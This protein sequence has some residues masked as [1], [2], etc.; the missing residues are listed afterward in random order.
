[1]PS[2]RKCVLYY[3]IFEFC[4]SSSVVRIFIFVV[5]VF[6]ARIS[7]FSKYPFKDNNNLGGR[8]RRGDVGYCRKEDKCAAE[9]IGTEQH[10]NPL[11]LVCI[12]FSP[13]PDFH[14]FFRPMIN[15]K[16]RFIFKTH[17]AC[18]PRHAAIS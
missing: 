15:F 17:V 5:R 18:H 3:Y 2:N 6:A 8:G 13:P 7:A 10:F 9:I 12:I 4:A 11:H 1:M 16:L 14:H